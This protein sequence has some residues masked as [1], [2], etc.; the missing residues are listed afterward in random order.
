MITQKIHQAAIKDV[1]GMAGLNQMP[2][3]PAAEPLNE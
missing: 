3:S 2:R 1:T